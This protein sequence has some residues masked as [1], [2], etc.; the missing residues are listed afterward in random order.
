MK[1][2]LARFVLAV[3]FLAAC[4]AGHFNTASAFTEGGPNPPLS[5]YSLFDGSAPYPTICPNGPCKP[6]LFDGS[7]P[8]PTICPNGPCPPSL[9]R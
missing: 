3:L 4:G 2:T 6:S 9:G 7:T 5:P 8:L 1:R